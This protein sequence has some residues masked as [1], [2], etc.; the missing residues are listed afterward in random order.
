MSRSNAWFRDAR[1]QRKILI[2][3]L[4]ILSF[5]F[6]IAA[7]VL[8]Q[9]RTLRLANAEAERV[10]AVTMAVDDLAIALEGRVSSFRDYLIA[11]QDTALTLIGGYNA[12]IAERLAEARSLT[13]EPEQ[14]A[15][16]NQVAANAETWE[17][18][19]LE[20]GIALRNAAAAPGGPGIDTVVAWFQTGVGRAG[21]I[22]M[23]SSLNEYRTDQNRRAA[24]QR[25]RVDVAIREMTWTT[26]IATVV[27]FILGFWLT[28]LVARQIATPLEE[29]VAFAGAV[30][31]GDLTREMRASSSDEIGDLVDTLNRM[32]ADLRRTIGGVGTATAQVATA[33]EQ[34]AATTEEISYTVDEQ[35]RSAEETSSSMEQIAAQISRVSTSTESLASSVEQTA[36]SISQMSTSNEET[37]RRTD[38]LGASVE[39][40]SATIEE[41]VVSINQVGRHV[42]ETRELATRAEADAGVGREIVDRSS[43][44]MR[45]VQ[46]EVDQLTGMMRE[47]ASSSESVSRVSEVIQ[48]IADQTNLLALNAAIEAARAGEEGRGFAVVAQEIRRLAERAV[49]STREITA[50]IRDVLGEVAQTEKSTTRVAERTQEGLRLAAD[51]SRALTQITDSAGRTRTLMEEVAHATDQQTTAA[52]QAQQAIRHIMQVAEEM[53]ISAREQ[54]YGSRQIVQAVENMNRQTQ[55]VFTATTEQKRGG[56]MILQATESI[57]GGLR[58]TQGAVQDMASA[59][60]D[61]S[62]QA[63]RLSELVR[64][65]RV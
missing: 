40:T 17:R 14:L 25:T 53:R 42:E 34:I 43:E 13:T 24:E 41:M 48:D 60:E 57:G 39:Q 31:G 45:R 20:P 62:S 26:V 47:L 3:N 15:R 27:A 9:T 8:L 16:L 22:R 59:A 55:E 2:V 23:R 11:G 37:A 28:N 32:A 51:A 36:S 46:E 65:F 61:L 49:E 44:G 5:L 1:I 6:L 63:T 7:V 4:V 52:G 54:A 58:A 21:A 30:A 56:E 19:I 64:Q 29:A 33:A 12:R 35:V 50:T 38:A 10:E 18:E